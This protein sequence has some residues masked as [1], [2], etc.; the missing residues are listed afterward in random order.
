[1]KFSSPFDL[2]LKVLQFINGFIGECLFHMRQFSGEPFPQHLVMHFPIN[3]WPSA[4]R[5]G[6][7][8]SPRAEEKA[9]PLPHVEKYH[10]HIGEVH[11]LV[12]SP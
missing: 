11:L 8:A 7:N 6:G 4:T 9:L 3:S 2:I 1:M 12:K 10:S 5:D